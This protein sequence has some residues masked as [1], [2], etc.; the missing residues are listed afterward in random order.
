MKPWLLLILVPF[1]WGA[2]YS[3][4]LKDG[5]VTRITQMLFFLGNLFIGLA[6]VLWMGDL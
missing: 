2:S 4:W 3:I 1:C 5:R 6:A